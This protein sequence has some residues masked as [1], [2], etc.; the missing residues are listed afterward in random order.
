MIASRAFARTI[1]LLLVAIGIALCLSPAFAQSFT[2]TRPNYAVFNVRNYGATGNGS[3]DDTAAIK[4]AETAAEA[5]CCGGVV[6]FPPGIYLVSTGPITIAGQGIEWLCQGGVS[7]QEG[8]NFTGATLMNN[9]NATLVNAVSSAQSM[10]GPLFINCNF[11]QA[12]G[13]ARGSSTIG[14]HIASFLNGHFW[15]GS[16][17]NFAIGIQL[18]CSVAN[19]NSNW[20]FDGHTQYYNNAISIDSVGSQSI[21]AGTFTA[22]DNYFNI[23]QQGDV[24]INIAAAG[25]T[26]GTIIGNR[27]DGTTSG[28]PVPLNYFVEVSA[29]EAACTIV[30]NHIEDPVAVYIDWTGSSGVRGCKIADNYVIDGNDGTEYTATC[31]LSGSGATSLT[32]CTAVIGSL[33]DI[34][35]GMVVCGPGLHAW[36]TTGWSANALPSTSGATFVASAASGSTIA[37]DTAAT[38]TETSQTYTFGYPPYRWGYQTADTNPIIMHGNSYSNANDYCGGGW[39]DGQ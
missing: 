34:E 4:A 5:L 1:Q 39:T 8:S 35:P 9:S 16:I 15:G 2:A 27:V 33:S 21:C 24:G 31:S 12:S 23:R 22:N 10:E 17:Q 11:N 14:L 38:A 26:S 19:D 18:D 3:T 28:T 6:E 30:G 37:I 20:L 36:T 29:Y 32:S 25:G 13:T 7:S